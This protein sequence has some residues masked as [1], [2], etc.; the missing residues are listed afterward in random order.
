MKNFIFKSSDF[1]LIKNVSNKLDIIL[2]EQ[3]LQRQDLA[4][5]LRLCNQIQNNLNINDQA[6]DYYQE[7][8][9][10]AYLGR[11]TSPQTD[12]KEQ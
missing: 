10:E 6:K 2:T 1:G 11:E 7:K 8:L 5:L 12:S 3:R 4:N 9:G